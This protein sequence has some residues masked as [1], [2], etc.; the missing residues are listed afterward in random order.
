ME[1]KKHLE[2]VWAILMVRGYSSLLGTN[3]ETQL[4]S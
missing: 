3:E 1:K 4:D 2:A